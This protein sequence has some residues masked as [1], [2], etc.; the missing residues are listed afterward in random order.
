MH[1]DVHECTEIGYVGDHAFQLHSLLEDLGRGYLRIEAD[2]PEFLPR[3]RS[4]ALQLVQN[5]PEGGFAYLA[6]YVPGQ[7]DSLAEVF[8]SHEPHNICVQV[9]GHVFDQFVSFRVDP[10]TVQGIV[11]V[12]DPEEPGALL[13][14]LLA[15]KPA[16]KSTCFSM[17]PPKTFPLGLASEG[18]IITIIS[19]SDSSG[20]F[21]V[22]SLVADKITRSKLVV[23][24]YISNRRKSL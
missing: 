5:V 18:S 21:P 19:A 6:V 17:T 9:P 1:T 16:I 11:A 7:I 2:G 12:L 14:C 15:T 8:A 23:S 10:R 3:I 24:I 20:R 22:P 13:E 4:R